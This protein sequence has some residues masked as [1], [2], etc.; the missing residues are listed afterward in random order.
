MLAFRRDPTRMQDGFMFDPHRIRGPPIA[1]P[2]WGGVGWKSTQ[3]CVDKQRALAV[4]FNH[5]ERRSIRNEVL[6]TLLP[7]FRKA[8][9]WSAPVSL[10]KVQ[11]DVYGTAF[12]GL[13]FH[14]HFSGPRCDSSAAF[15]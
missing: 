1:Q 2:Q 12:A 8:P 14:V 6:R 3:K 9:Q 7:A 11:A 15:A 10:L 4:L 5:D 13:G